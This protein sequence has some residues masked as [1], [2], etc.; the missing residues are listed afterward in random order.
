VYNKVRMTILSSREHSCVHPVVSKGK[1]K[2]EECKKLLDGSMGTTCRYYQKVHTIR[3]QTSLRYHGLATAWDIEDLVTLGGQIKACPYYAARELMKEADII[4]CPYNYLIDPKIRMQMEISLKDQIVVLDEAHNVEDSARDAASLTLTAVDLQ[5]TLDDLDRLVQLQVFTDHH[6]SLH[7]MVGSF[8]RWIHDSSAHL[9]ERSFEQSSKVWSGM[10][11]IGAMEKQGITPGT[12]YIYYEHFQYLMTAMKDPSRASDSPSLTSHSLSLLEGIFL[13]GK[14]MMGNNMQYIADYRCAILKTSVMVRDAVLPGGW[15]RA[16]GGMRKEWTHS[17]NFWCLNPAVVFSEIGSEAWCIVLTSGTLSPMTSFSSELGIKFPIQLEANHVI[18]NSQVWVGTLSAGP[19]GS[20]INASYRS[21]ETFTF[22]DEVGKMVLNICE[23]VPHGVLCFFPSYNMLDKL[24]KRWQSTGLWSKLLDRKVLVSEPRSGDKLEFD[25]I[26]H[27]FYHAVR[28]SEGEESDEQLDSDDDSSVDGGLFLAVCRGKVS[29][30]LDFADNNARA[31]ITIGIPFP[32]VKDV[33]VELKRKYN[34]QYS[35]SRG[36]LTGSE[37]YEIQAYRALNQALGRCIRHKQDWGAIV[38]ID[39]RFNK[40]PRYINGISKWVRKRITQ[41]NN[42]S[43]A[44]SSLKEFASARKREPCPANTSPCSVS[45]L[46]RSSVETPVKEQNVHADVKPSVEH[47]SLLD[48]RGNQ[49]GGVTLEQNVHAD[50]KPFEEHAR[51]PD[52]QENQTGRVTLEQSDLCATPSQ[53][54]DA[55]PSVELTNAHGNLAGRFRLDHSGNC[56]TPLQSTDS[57]PSVESK[58]VGKVQGNP[59]DGFTLE[60]SAHSTTPFQRIIPSAKQRSLSNMQGN[61]TSGFTPSSNLIQP[62]F[63]GVTSKGLSFN[64]ERVAS[65]LD[66][67]KRKNVDVDGS[68]RK[69]FNGMTLVLD[70]KPV[71]GENFVTVKSNELKVDGKMESQESDSALKKKPESDPLA[72]E[73]MSSP[74]LFATPQSTPSPSPV[75]QEMNWMIPREGEE[76]TSLNSSKLNL[77]V[78]EPNAIK[79]VGNGEGSL[80]NCSI[81]LS[82]KGG[83]FGK[84]SLLENTGVQG[85]VAVKE[86]LKSKEADANAP[87]HGGDGNELNSEKKP[88]DILD[89]VKEDFSH[90]KAGL[91]NRLQ[92]KAPHVDRNTESKEAVKE[93]V[94]NLSSSSRRSERPCNSVSEMP[95]NV[96]LGRR[97]STRLRRFSNSSKSTREEEKAASEEKPKDESDKPVLYCARCGSSLVTGSFASNSFTKHIPDALQS[98]FQQTV[99]EK[100]VLV[101]DKETCTMSNL[102]SLI[103]AR[104]DHSPG[105]KLN[106]L[107]VPE[108]DSCYIPLVC[109]VCQTTS[110]DSGIVGVEVVSFGSSS[111]QQQCQPHPLKQ[112]WLFPG[113]VNVH[114]PASE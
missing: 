98:S 20:A 58:H 29:E 76:R 54:S 91:E 26:M 71:N 105:M 31:V 48:N 110:G 104:N 67:F 81:T 52:N 88:R 32:N 53:C 78:E 22:Q 103:D 43:A 1:N 28:T 17:L 7:L 9:R 25:D 24:S 65:K 69:V 109:R 45:Q 2:N 114:S 35:A 85:Y 61:Q 15:R 46:S 82:K 60:H 44:M 34:T 62:A 80:G 106:S 113:L 37:W 70:F 72:R 8:L 100:N 73:Q 38:L 19:S 5:N 12:F 51:L 36:L 47:I 86:L 3:T 30:G 84:S 87:G 4:F 11:I 108:C 94:L 18:A 57:K 97:R 40:S 95:S 93:G 39:E 96:R 74:L 21:A 68:E 79:N 77:G 107:F 50:V 92:T 49:T 99:D 64:A 90:E 16:H 66:K 101:I 6:K 102:S 83:D 89:D 10:E 33:Q 41:Y 55:R 112:V 111:E 27:Q 13:I 23:T 14:F 75:R 42:F 63:S 56:G 59:G